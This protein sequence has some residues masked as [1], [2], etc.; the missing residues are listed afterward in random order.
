MLSRSA[1]GVYWMGRYLTRAQH[2][3]RLLELHVQALV[4]RSVEEINFGWRRI[5]RTTRRLPPPEE[6]WLLEAEE[7]A[8]ADAFTLADD[9]TFER[10]NPDS[11]WGCLAS[12]RENARQMRHCIS[13][14]MWTCLNR[15]YLRLRELETVDIWKTPKVFYA[16][17]CNDIHHF[18]GVADSTMYR[19]EAW[20]F[21]RL[22]QAI[23]R[24]QFGASLLRAQIVV[25][26]RMG[27]SRLGWA[28]LLRIHHA[29]GAY[30]KAHGIEVQPERVLDLLVT[31]AFLPAAL[32]SGVQAAE[33]ELAAI[34]SGP[35]HGTDAAV[36]RLVGRVGALILYDWPETEAREEFVRRLGH[37]ARDLHQAVMAA[38]VEYETEDSP[39]LGR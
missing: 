17:V 4:D 31:D 13:G 9:L 12:G 24:I 35:D 27:R 8:L 5:Y 28:S 7:F 20:R 29:S 15:S 39:R 18:V 36:R 19:G 22:G 2:M 30:S 16:G 14:E 25:G 37:C 11:V 26:R 3:S 32:L 6:Q 10:S 1:K 23:E 34:E 38:F 21:M 33:A